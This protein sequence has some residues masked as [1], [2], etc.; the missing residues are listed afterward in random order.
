MYMAV[1]RAVI[2][3]QCQTL[4]IDITKTGIEGGNASIS[5][6]FISVIFSV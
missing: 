5:L 2:L 4:K 3:K 6:N 1:P